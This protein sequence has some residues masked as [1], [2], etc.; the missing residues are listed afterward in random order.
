[1]SK[2]FKGKYYYYK[3]PD[4]HGE[5]PVQV[6]NVVTTPSESRYNKDYVKVKFKVN[7]KVAY[8]K[9]YGVERFDQLFKRVPGILE[10]LLTIEE[11]SKPC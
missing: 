8:F 2:P 10:P 3:Y 7:S 5:S 9:Y 11:R 6:D 1:M 4:I